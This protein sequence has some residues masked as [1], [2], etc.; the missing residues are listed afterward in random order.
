MSILITVDINEETK[1][2]GY[3][4]IDF[5]VNG[6]CHGGVRMAPDLSPGSLARAARV[7]TLKYGFL[8]LP[9]GG[10]KAGIVADPEMP[11]ADKR[12]L[13]KSFGQALKPILQTKNYIPSGDLG[14][15]DDDVK[16]ML[17]ANG[18]KVIP[19]TLTFKISGFY[20]GFTVFTAAVRAAEHIGLD[21]SRASVAI[22]GFGSVGSSVAQA[23]WK[24]GIKVVAV[25]TAQGAIYSEEGLDIE[26]MIKMQNE[27]GSR[28]VKLFTRGEQMDKEKLKELDVD[29]FCPCAHSYSIT[30]DNAQRVRAK[31]IS[32][33]ANVP[34]TSEAEPILLRK[35]VFCIPDFMANCGGVLGSSMKRA[36]LGDDFIWHFIEEKFGQRITDMIKAA[37]NK[38]IALGEYAERVAMERFLKAKQVAENKSFV[39][40]FFNLALE[41]YRSGAIP[42][43]LITPFAPKYFEKKLEQV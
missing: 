43:R 29:V 30:S 11:Q 27:V 18:I 39:N 9:A 36:G 24:R 6:S 35:G 26:E 8:G 32:P 14:V 15:S 21:L 37:E 16:F 17:T 23:F 20:T 41:L 4:A 5:M 34:A 12:G 7:M 40:K 28:V 19:R 42:Y 1:L 33:G 31:I 10:A 25:S 13:L 22:E 3:L 38:N 2:K